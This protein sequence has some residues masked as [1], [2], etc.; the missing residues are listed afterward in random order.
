MVIILDEENQLRFIQFDRFARK[1]SQ[2]ENDFRNWELREWLAHFSK[3]QEK[4]K[5]RPEMGQAGNIML[6]GSEPW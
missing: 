1:R 2:L 4:A 5:Q 6:S 3:S